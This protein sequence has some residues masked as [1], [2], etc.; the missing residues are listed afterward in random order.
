MGAVFFILMIIKSFPVVPSNESNRRGMRRHETASLNVQPG[1]SGEEMNSLH[2]IEDFSSLESIDLCET[3]LAEAGHF[4]E[5]ERG[6]E[7]VR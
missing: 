3:Y 7:L 5:V 6:I 2:S 1:P 4:Q